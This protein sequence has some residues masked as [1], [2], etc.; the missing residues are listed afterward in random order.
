MLPEIIEIA[1]CMSE[2]HVAVNVG[3]WCVRVM[4]R[5][6][7]AMYNSDDDIDDDSDDDDDDDVS[8]SSNNSSVPGRR[9]VSTIVLYPP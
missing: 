6:N 9:G 1:S 2:E 5:Q 3:C 8:S 7:P 4:W